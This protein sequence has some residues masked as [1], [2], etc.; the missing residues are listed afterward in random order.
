MIHLMS[1]EGP[2]LATFHYEL[3]LNKVYGSDVRSSSHQFPSRLH[4]TIP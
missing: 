2:P 4:N 1:T 3:L